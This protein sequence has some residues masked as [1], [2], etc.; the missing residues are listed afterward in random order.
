MSHI[1]NNSA[2]LEEEHEERKVR[3]DLTASK[4]MPR[5]G[6]AVSGRDLGEWCTFSI[7]QFP[8]I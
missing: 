5:A 1:T 8:H 7:N 4:R 2:W 3:F 6:V